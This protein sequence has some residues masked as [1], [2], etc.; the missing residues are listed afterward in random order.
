VLNVNNGTIDLKTGKL[1]PHDSNQKLSKIVPIDYDPT[2]KCPRWSSFLYRVMDDD[3]DMIDFLQRAVGYTLT[4]DVGGQCLFFTHGMGAN[5]KSVF[6]EVLL[7]LLGEYGTNTRA[8]TIMQTRNTGIPNDIARLVGKRFVGVSEIELGQ[9]MAESL[10]KDLTGGDTISARFLHKE[11]FD[12]KPEF[13]LWIRGNHKPNIRGTDDGIW[14]RIHLIPFDVQIPVAER[15]GSLP[16]KLR[17]E[18]PGILRWAVDG[19]IAWL[20]DGLRVPEKVC[21][22]TNEYRNDMDR[23]S[24]FI[25][26]RCV[27]DPSCSAFAGA[28]F[29]SY[30]EWCEESGERYTSQT[31]FG[32]A[33]GERGYL[34]KKIN[35]RIKY[36]GIG[37]SVPHQD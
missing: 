19:A 16:D 20:Q 23:L 25:A 29:S 8:E 27:V 36:V 10:I 26:E 6:L 35:G 18:L 37:L 32:S 12:F 33:L 24:D 28:L 17:E 21:A 15:D 30:K 11:Y 9:K 4:G 22:A 3:D 34:K 13:K 14:R 5:G 2:A 1:R 7:Q 31:A